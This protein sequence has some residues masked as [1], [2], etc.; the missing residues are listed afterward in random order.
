MPRGNGSGPTGAGRGGRPGQQNN[1]GKGGFGQQ[2]SVGR[3]RMDGP[4]SA[5]PN[6]FCVCPQ[7]GKKVMHTIAE[8]C[9]T[10][11]CPECGSAMTR[12]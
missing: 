7:C 8:P 5:G 11:K 3:G 6:G 1:S 2:K 4:A 9:N 12:E 10:I